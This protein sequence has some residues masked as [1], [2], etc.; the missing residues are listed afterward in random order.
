MTSASAGIPWLWLLS[1]QSS[2][3][4]CLRKKT[5]GR[6]PLAKMEK[7]LRLHQLTRPPWVRKTHMTYISHWCVACKDRSER[8]MICHNTSNKKTAHHSK[9]CR[10]LDNFD[11]EGKYDG[12]VYN[13]KPN[14]YVSLYAHASHASDELTAYPL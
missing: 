11:Y 14:S 3:S 7:Y 12:S 4:V 9:D 6:V 13:S 8:C 1:N 5:L 10:I 2:I